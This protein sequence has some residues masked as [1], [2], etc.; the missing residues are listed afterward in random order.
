MSKCYAGLD[1]GDTETAICVID[2]A[3]AVLFEHRVA[4]NAKIIA[5]ELKP[6]RRILDGVAIETGT[7]SSRLFKELQRLRY[8]MV[9]LDAFH[10]HGSLVA[11]R[12]KMVCPGHA[13]V[14]L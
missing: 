11:Q 9:C 5:T 6:Y 3:A 4:S 1:V 13:G 7:T 14:Q 12:N 8:P 10:A 2:S